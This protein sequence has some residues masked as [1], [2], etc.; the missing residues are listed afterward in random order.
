MP[1][2]AAS[3]WD[4]ARIEYVRYLSE[5]GRARLPDL[6]DDRQDIGRMVVGRRTNGL[7]SHLPRLGPASAPRASHHTASAAFVRVLII[8]RSFSASAA[9]R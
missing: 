8:A 2:A 4:T 7:Q 5:R 6:A 1:L 9:N 3:R